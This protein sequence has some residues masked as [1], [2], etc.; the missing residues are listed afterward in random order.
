MGRIGLE[1]PGLA[2]QGVL[3]KDSTD[4]LKNI[5]SNY[6]SGEVIFELES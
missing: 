1:L 6:D 2:S 3:N 4:W 5:E